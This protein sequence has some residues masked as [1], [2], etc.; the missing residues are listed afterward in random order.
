[1]SDELVRDLQAEHSRVRITPGVSHA[2]SDAE[3][4]QDDDRLAQSEGRYQRLIVNLP[5]V[6]WTTAEDGSV[7]YVSPNVETLYGYTPEEI[8]SAGSEFWFRNLHPEDHPLVFEAYRAMFAN[9]VPYD[10]EYRIRRK[11]GSWVW[12]RSRSSGTY[13]HNG[14]RYADGL[15][16]DI[17][18]RKSAEAELIAKTAFLEAQTNSTVDGLL[19]VDEHGREILHNQKFVEIFRIPEKILEQKNDALMI[20]YAMN[21][22]IKDPGKFLQQVNYLYVHPDLTRRDEVELTDGTVLD[23]YSSPVVGKDGTYYGRIWTFR[24]ITDQKRAIEQL[25]ENQDKL[26]LILESTAEAIYGIDAQGICTFCNPACLRLLGYENSEQLVGK[27]IH[28]L[29]HHSLRDGSPLSLDDCPI[30]RTFR[31]GRGTHVDSEVMWKADGTSFPVEYW[32]YPQ[33]REGAVIGAVVTFVD[34]TERKLA[35]ERIQF[36]AYYDALT[37]LPN[38]TLLQDRLNTALAGARRHQEKV[39]LLF[40]DIDRFKVINDSLGHSIGDV[41]LKQVAERLRNSARE[42]DTVARLG[43]D[44]FLIVLTA[45]R[46]LSGIGVAADRF[47]KAMATPFVIQEHSLT[48]TCSLGITIFPEHGEDSES[49]L[50]NADVALYSAKDQGRNKFQFFTEDMNVQAMERLTLENNLR[51]ALLRRSELVLYYQPQVRIADGKI[52]GAEALVRWQHPDLGLIMPDRFIAIAENSGL[53]N[54]IG[55]WVLKT[56]CAQAMQWQQQGLPSIPVAV[57]VSAV[58]LRQ[59]GFVQLIR[60]VLAES[61]L[62]ARYLELE[63]TESVILTNAD[64]MLALLHELA[65]LGVKLS[66]DDFGIGYSSLSYLKHFPFH[67]LKIDRSFIR[68]LTTD[69]EDAAITSAIINLAKNLDLGVVAEGVENDEQMAFLRQHECDEAQG[70]YFSRPL[71]AC[72]FT[73]FLPRQKAREQD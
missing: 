29:I 3:R 6:T 54:P 42:Q 37:G 30:L 57:N 39:A 4:G 13:D 11:D 50:K 64:V 46:S 40:L 20:Q 73:E 25:Q 48:V 38:R 47:L 66:I 31:A 14:I 52:T 28:E 41:L 69:P 56:A 45:I 8:C 70:Y 33:C 71:P 16:S 43:G 19:V 27:N 9:N 49:L 12:A 21:H 36:L 59:E 34:I 67:K 7:V 23:R 24:D 68:D 61:G 60:N 32:S 65:V 2:T 15:V 62:A 63:L 44:E 18:A 35:Q 1:M 17:S 51:L 10:V 72:S 55:E 26:S 53:I 58:Q 22:I 5:D